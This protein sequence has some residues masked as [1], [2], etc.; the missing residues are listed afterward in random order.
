MKKVVLTLVCFVVV[1]LGA[2]TWKTHF[3]RT[4]SQIQTIPIQRIGPLSVQE[5][6]MIFKLIAQTIQDGLDGKERSYPDLNAYP[7]KWREEKTVYTTLYIG[8]NLRGYRGNL[9]HKKPLLHAIVDSAYEAAF[10]DSRF[11]KLTQQEFNNPDFYSYIT[12][13]GDE[14]QITFKNEKDIIKQLTPFQYGYIL[15]YQPKRGGKK[16]GLFLPSVWKKNPNPRQFWK[17]LKKKAKLRET[18]FS[19]K[20]EVYAFSAETI[21]DLDS[22]MHQDAKR[23][24]SALT[25]YKKLFL[26]NGHVR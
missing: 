25:A 7:S 6:Q 21:R 22:T 10:Q 26:P 23:I 12:I 18:F 17:K 2:Y 4:S 13:F 11:P 9:H 14:K 24:Q 3:V 8:H 19:N 20:F 1:A 16:R 15:V 5:R